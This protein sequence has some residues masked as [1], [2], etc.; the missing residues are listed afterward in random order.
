MRPGKFISVLV[1]VGILAG[2]AVGAYATRERWLPLVFPPPK[3]SKVEEKKEDGGS[4]ERIK[5][6]PQAQA[7]LKLDVDALVPEPYMRK[8]LIPGIVVDRPGVTDRGVT[9]RVAG[10]VGEI[11]ARPGD[12]VKAGDPLFTLQLVGEFV[13]STQTELAKAARELTF[14][15]AKRVR[16]ADLV[17]QGTQ[18]PAELIEAENQVKRVTTQVQAYRRQLQVLGLTAAQVGLAEK[19]NV[20]TELV[21]TA[22]DRPTEG[23]PIEPKGIASEAGKVEPP[24]FEVQELKVQ[25]GEAV[26]AG[27]TL[28]LLSNHQL[29]YVEGRA[30]KSEAKALAQAAKEGW[31][32]TAEFAEETPG[33]WNKTEPLT[34]RHLSN[35]VD[36]ATRSF[37]F[38]LPLKNES[39]TYLKDGK[40]Y[41]VWR[42][43]PGQRVRLKVPIEKLADDVFIL[44]SGAVVREGAEAFVFRQNG[45][46]FERKPVRVLYE[47]RIEVVLANDGSVGAGQFVVRNQA[48]AL[49]RAIKAAAGGGGGGGHEGHNH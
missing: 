30:F 44:P 14:A 31:P 6:S 49:N 46:L 32:V 42:F 10:I 2:I 21:V 20:V 23:V 26:T 38:Y 39:D 28:C 33:E 48:A 45:D 16:T 25:L 9:A 29:L 5:L 11:K 35:T 34:I 3:S 17:K 12:T 47:D 4:V 7:N 41:F 22:P 13:Q 24:V 18:A 40:T 27:Q 43:R 15:E 1:T 37:A 8:L 19:G 36:V